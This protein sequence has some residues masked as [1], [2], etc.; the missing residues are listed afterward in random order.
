MPGLP[1]KLISVER[2]YQWYRDGTAWKYEPVVSTKQVASGSAD[3][4]E[5]GA[6]ISVPV[7]WG[8][9]RLEIEAAALDGR[10]RA[11]SSMR[12][13][14]SRPPRRR[15]RTGWRSHSTR[16]TMR[17]ANG[18][19]QGL[20]RFAGE[21]LVTV[22]TETRGDDEDRGHCRKPAARWNCR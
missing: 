10:L 21:L 17:S 16:K 22:G 9:Y 19:A 12:A 20:A 2:N 7:G 4:T 11:L 13:G 5:D 6:E 15:P 18:E 14:M 1:W 3:V 8:R